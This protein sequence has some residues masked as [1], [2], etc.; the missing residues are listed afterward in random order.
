MAARHFVAQDRFRLD[1]RGPI[2]LAAAKRLAESGPA[3][4][5]WPGTLAPKPPLAT[6]QRI[7]PVGVSPI[8]QFSSGP[9]VGVPT[10]GCALSSPGNRHGCRIAKSV[11]EGP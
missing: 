1:Y 8:C 5:G 10:P 11:A 7:T 2:R 9:P 6:P 3:P 4:N